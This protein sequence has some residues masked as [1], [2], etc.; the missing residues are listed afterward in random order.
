MGCGPSNIDLCDADKKAE[1]ETFQAM[2]ADELKAAI[3]EKETELEAAEST[4]KSE[5]EKLQ[6]KYEQ[7][8]KDKDATIAAVKDSGLGLMKAV[9]ASKYALLHCSSAGDGATST[10][11]LPSASMRRHH[12]TSCSRTTKTTNEAPRFKHH[13][14]RSAESVGLECARRL[15]WLF[16]RHSVAC[17]ARST[18]DE[19][20]LPAGFWV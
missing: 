2:S 18:S 20:R 17:R 10:R 19:G 7:L 4:F 14:S 15:V 1:I 3:A 8:S 12:P 13:G 6:K 5:V 16:I 11:G 9:K